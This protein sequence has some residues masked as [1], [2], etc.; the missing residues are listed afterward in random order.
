MARNMNVSTEVTKY[1]KG[2]ANELVTVEEICEALNLDSTQARYAMR[3]LIEKTT[4][5]KFIAVVNRGNTWT[6]GNIPGARKVK[7]APEQ[8]PTIVDWSEVADVRPLASYEQVGV[9]GEGK[10]IVR[11]AE[12]KLYRV[13]PL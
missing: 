10:P 7:A 9:T 6:V 12:G 8:V 13:I 3:R 11:D 1:I 2:R 5:G 4:L